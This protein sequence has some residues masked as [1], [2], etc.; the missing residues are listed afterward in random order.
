MKNSSNKVN[1]INSWKYVKLHACIFLYSITS[2]L[3]KAAANFA[4]FSLPY[5]LCFG[6]LAVTLG[7]Y[8]ILW[9]QEIKEFD[10]SV[11]YSHKSVTVV[12]TMLYS[13]FIFGENITLN[14]LLG[15]VLII[16]GI[17]V[18]TYR[19]KDMPKFENK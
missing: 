5:I 19:R 16:A 14:N 2:V 6:L 13:Y 3:I 8:A 17:I 4:L 12:W 1:L 18:V 11:A 9:Q 15:T 10:P 7:I